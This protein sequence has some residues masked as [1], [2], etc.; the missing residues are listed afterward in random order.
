MRE[1]IHQMMSTPISAY[2]F[3]IGCGSFIQTILLTL[4]VYKGGKDNDR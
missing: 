1:L 2:F 3:G 4:V